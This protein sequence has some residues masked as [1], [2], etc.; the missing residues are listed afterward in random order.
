MQRFRRRHP[1]EI[2]A[3]ASA[4]V[5]AREEAAARLA[6]TRELIAAQSERARR[7]RA[8]IIAAVRRIRE[9]DSLAGLILDEVERGTGGD[10]G[11]DSGRT[12]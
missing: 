9:Q 2:R 12:H 8:T 3:S 5:S 1:K 11:A 6:E 7:E 10:P 4:A